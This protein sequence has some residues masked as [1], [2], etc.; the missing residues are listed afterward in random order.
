MPTVVGVTLK[1]AA[2]TLIGAEDCELS[3]GDMVIV[4]SDHGDEI[5]RVSSEPHE[6]AEGRPAD[7]GLR[8]VRMA[9]RED[10]ERAEELRAKER[11]AMLVYR[12]LIGKLGLDMK[13]TDVEYLFDGARAIFYFVAEERVDFRDLVRD[14]AAE[15]HVR[16]DMRQIGVRDEARLIGGLG[17]CGQQLCCA[18]MGGE[19][20]PVTIRMAKEQDLPLNPLKISGVCGRLMCCLRYEFEAYRDFKGRAP[21]KGAIVDIGGTLGKVVELDTP[22]ERVTMRREDGSRVTFA[23]ADLD[24]GCEGQCACKVKTEA[25][26]RSLASLGAGTAFSATAMGAGRGRRTEQPS[27][28]AAS[29]EPAA[30]QTAKQAAEPPAAEPARR[31]RRRRGGGASSEQPAATTGTQPGARKRQPKP[32]GVA[33]AP[34]AEGKSEGAASSHRKRR[35][36]RGGGS[37]PAAG[38]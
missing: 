24:C 1:D 35:R 28:A 4:R 6:A 12:R 11:E 7:T 8:I 17:H 14:L 25:M 3:V 10:T 36:R 5:G 34:A 19:F 18:R 23:L 27:R 38:A 2:S 26:E 15:L 13:P 21:K 22:R 16:V 37:T 29:P 31:R 20:Q 30:K 32:P 9:T 33:P